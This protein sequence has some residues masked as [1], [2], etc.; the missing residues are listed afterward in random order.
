MKQ[1]EE[2]LGAIPVVDKLTP[3]LMEEIDDI[4][5]TKPQVPVPTAMAHRIRVQDLRHFS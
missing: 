3:A 2:N 1:V 5:G 4:I